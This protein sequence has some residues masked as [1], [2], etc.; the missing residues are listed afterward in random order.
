MSD[1]SEISPSMLYRILGPDACLA[2]VQ[3]QASLPE[4]E[5]NK[6]GAA[7]DRGTRIHEVAAAI[8]EGTPIPH[9]LDDDDMT[10]AGDYVEY[11]QGIL[12]TYDSP[13]LFVEQKL[14]MDQWVTDM[15]GTAD[16]IIYADGDLHIIDLKTGS[17]LVSPDDNP[18]LKAY[19]LGALEFIGEP[20]ER[21]FMSIF[22]PGNGAL[23]DQTTPDDLYEFGHELSLAGMNA[24][25]SNP[26]FN[27]TEKNCQYCDAAPKCPALY[28]QTLEVARNDLDVLPSVEL[29][30]D[31]Q[32]A[33]VIEK[34]NLVEGWMRQVQKYAQERAEHGNAIPGT[35]LVEGR[36]VRQWTAEAEDELVQHLGDKAYNK[37]LIGL[38]EA[39][40]LVGKELVSE[41][42]FKPAGK[43]TVVPVSDK[44]P[45]VANVLD[46][47]NSL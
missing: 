34:R 21:V 17:V 41:L 38:G 16:A 36:T 28:Q 1:H 22:Q 46:D 32:I 2:S 4:A 24:Y 13:S 9:D 35:K 7:A 42:T 27:P 44:R 14:S 3:A 25:F 6:G 18:Q 23:A 12:S 8:L 15:R 19:A 37:K 43:P 31:D 30:T 39:E 20:V 40:K 5:R 45:E 47:L 33:L 11:V 26:D 29:M 10:I